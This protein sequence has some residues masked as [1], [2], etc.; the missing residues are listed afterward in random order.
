[1]KEGPRKFKIIPYWI[2]TA[3]FDWCLCHQVSCYFQLWK[4]TTDFQSLQRISTFPFPSDSISLNMVLKGTCDNHYL[5]PQHWASYAKLCLN[6]N[7]IFKVNYKKDKIWNFKS[8]NKTLLI[9]ATVIAR[10]WS[11]ATQHGL[12]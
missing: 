3:F 1:M 10:H 7:M 6:E 4:N 9:E 12:F 2:Q 5:L 11:N 8:R